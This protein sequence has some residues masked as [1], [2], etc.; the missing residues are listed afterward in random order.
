MSEKQTD[1]PEKK[2]HQAEFLLEKKGQQ[3]SETVLAGSLLEAENKDTG[4]EQKKGGRRDVDGQHYLKAPGEESLSLPEEG[5]SLLELEDEDASRGR[6]TKSSGPAGADAGISS[7]LRGRPRSAGP[8]SSGPGSAGP[9]RAGPDADA[10]TMQVA[11]VRPGTSVMQV[12]GKLYENLLFAVMH[13]ASHKTDGL[14]HGVLWFLDETKNVAPPCMAILYETIAELI[15]IELPGI[16]EVIAILMVW[17][18]VMC[19]CK[20]APHLKSC[21]DDAAKTAIIGLEKTYGFL[22]GTDVASLLKSAMKMLVT[23]IV[24]ILLEAEKCVVAEI[25]VLFAKYCTPCNKALGRLAKIAD[26]VMAKFFTVFN[27]NLREVYLEE[28][29]PC[30]P[31]DWGDGYGC[32]CGHGYGVTDLYC[33]KAAGEYARDTFGHD[34]AE[35]QGF[36]V[37]CLAKEGDPGARWF[38][39]KKNNKC[40]GA[41]GVGSA[42]CCWASPACKSGS[43][44]SSAIQTGTRGTPAIEGGRTEGGSFKPDGPRSGLRVLAGPSAE[45]DRSSVQVHPPNSPLDVDGQSIRGGVLSGTGTP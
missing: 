31:G 37:P 28:G 33:S 40:F 9:G 30:F 45:A 1:M 24:N 36:C 16:G 39:S 2:D 27:E 35:G 42:S 22:V 4:T 38:K 43:A 11:L 25:S 26:N 10:Q 41:T 6:Q 8:D 34:I 12:E 20:E 19:R 7:G 5:S 17:I 15:G 3:A 44:S 21:A 18:G 13:S 23:L 14:C 32:E 29:A